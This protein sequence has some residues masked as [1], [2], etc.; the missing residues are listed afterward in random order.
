MVWKILNLDF[1]YTF[2]NYR[3]ELLHFG[4]I[5]QNIFNHKDLLYFLIML[6]GWQIMCKWKLNKLKSFSRNKFII[7]KF[8]FWLIDWLIHP[9]YKNKNHKC[10]HLSTS[11]FQL[12]HLLSFSKK[13]VLFFLKFFDIRYLT[14]YW[15]IWE[16]F[17]Y[18]ETSASFF[19][20][21]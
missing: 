2:L 13:K 7:K 6:T 14:C 5:V 8:F 9:T 17:P 15:F 18:A 20:L 11:I 4:G 16:K 10:A 12:K 3:L 1:I 19:F 21:N